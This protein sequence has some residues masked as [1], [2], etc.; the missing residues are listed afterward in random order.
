MRTKSPATASPSD[1]AF[2]VLSTLFLIS[3]ILCH[4]TQ[5]LTSIHCMFHS[6][7]SVSPARLPAQVAEVM[8][9]EAK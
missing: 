1:D 8:E 2:G 4:K 7:A 5:D 6:L 3:S 9:S